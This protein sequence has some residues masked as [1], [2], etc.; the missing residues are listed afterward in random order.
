MSVRS[1]PESPGS[2]G[3]SAYD[4]VGYGM[5]FA[6]STLLFFIAGVWLDGR[7]GSSPLFAFLGLLVGGAAGFWWMYARLTGVGEVREEEEEDGP[8]DREVGG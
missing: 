5:T 3:G 7:L 4:A 2:E 6:I 8:T 1:G